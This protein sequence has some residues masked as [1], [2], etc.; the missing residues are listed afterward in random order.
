MSA[1]TVLGGHRQLRD[2]LGRFPTGV[3]VMTTVHHGVRAGVTVNS[4][5]SL[6]LDP[7]L[8]LWCLHRDSATMPAFTSAADFAVNIL[9]AGQQDLAIRFASRG[10]RFHGV[11]THDGPGGLPLLDAT[12]GTVICR[13]DRIF[14]AG[15][16][17]VFIGVVRDYLASPGS[18][19]LFVDGGYRA[20]DR[21]CS[22]THAS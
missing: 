16:H 20:H 14:P 22:L 6:S 19:L 12:V 15:D 18:P 10:E 3:T 7:P 17:I 1:R 5:T 4:F 21:A 11:A 9:A 8:V 13:R 2:V